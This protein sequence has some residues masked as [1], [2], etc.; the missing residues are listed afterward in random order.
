MT[1]PFAEVTAA[2]EIPK[3]IRLDRNLYAASFS[4]MKL[5]PARYILRRAVDDGRIG[6]ETLIAETTSGTFGLAL[7]M[8]AAQLG[9]RLVLVSDPAIDDRL[10]RRLTDL[11]AVVDRVRTKA[12]VGGYQRA[13]LDRLAEVRTEHPDSFCPEQYSNPD[14]PRSY[15]LVAEL[16]V[17]A[18]GQIDCLVGP[19]GSGGSM[20]GTVGFVRSLHPHCTAVGVD[21]Q[22]SVLFGHPDGHRGLRGLGNSLLPANLNH[23][24]F[25][26]VHWCSEP[27]AYR[28]TRELHQRHSLFKGPTSGAAYRV[29]HWWARNNPDAVTV[30]MLPDDG[31]RYQDTVYDDR[32]LQTAGHLSGRQPVEP[33][34]RHDVRDASGEWTNFAWGRR[35]LDDVLAALR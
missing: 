15:A 26:Q 27:V 19:V 32:W 5:I 34:P 13:R 14:N 20:C 10:Y 29:A 6:P 7:A 22:R 35:S 1:A 21:T 16:L 3:I 12:A 18:L 28:A 8:Q 9:R 24:V 30:V 33:E 4:L 23:R 31:Y 25:D 17:E 11:G 2:E